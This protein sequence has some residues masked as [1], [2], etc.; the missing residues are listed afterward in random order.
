[1]IL[2]NDENKKVNRLSGNE[3]IIGAYKNQKKK[4]IIKIILI[5]VI[6]FFIFCAF[7]L[8]I[9]FFKWKNIAKEM[10]SNE[11]SKVIDTEG[12][13]I[14]TLGDTRKVKNTKYE[15]IPE[16]IKDAYVS[17][18]DQRF[19]KHNGVDLP[20][21]AAAIFSYVRNVGSSSFGGSSITQQLVKN[22]TGD[23]SSKVS[24]KVKEWFKAWSLETFLSKEEILGSYLNIIYVGPNVYGVGAGANYYFSKD[25]SS[26]S[27][28]ECAFLAG[29]NN[30][31]NSYNPFGEKDN[32]EKITT[33]TIAVLNKMFELGYI[34]EDEKNSAINEVNQGLKFKQGKLEETKNSGI[35]SYHTDSLILEV[36]N[37]IEKK[38]HISED[39][40]ENYLNM[41]GLKIFSTEKPSI[42]ETI[43]KEAEKKKYI[44]YS[45]KESG[46]TSQIAMV[47]LDIKTG[48]VVRM[49]RW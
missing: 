36:M 40:A 14:A 4:K 49:C 1:M 24:R 47:V 44:I 13:V 6:F 25:L 20:R 5:I 35:Y 7:K 34:S 19:Y 21:T 46:K 8:I 11:P 39:F 23:S 28:A 31:P 16:N 29:I 43:E 9:S 32:N 17:I 38:K 37:D 41:A 10:I 45:T 12:N 30:S 33:R 27:L 18:E 48:E 15:D 26:L 42:Q 2:K 3:E 22:L